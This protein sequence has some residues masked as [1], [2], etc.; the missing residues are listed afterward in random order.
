MTA[1]EYDLFDL[2]IFAED[3]DGVFIYD[4]TIPEEIG[5]RT[6]EWGY[7]NEA[8]ES[9]FAGEKPLVQGGQ[10]YDYYWIGP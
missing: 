10:D 5:E 8:F 1:Q 7:W 3:A 4:S 6:R 2:A 9:L